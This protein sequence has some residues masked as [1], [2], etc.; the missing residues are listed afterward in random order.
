[1]MYVFAY[2]NAEVSGGSGG[3]SGG[4]VLRLCVVCKRTF[5]QRNDNYSKRTKL[6]GKCYTQNP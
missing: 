3:N 5:L 6:K 2:I 4:D 1:M